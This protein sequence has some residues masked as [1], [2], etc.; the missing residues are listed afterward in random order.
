M[1]EYGEDFAPTPGLI[2]ILRI[3]QSSDRDPKI[4]VRQIE[5]NQ[6]KKKTGCSQPEKTEKRQNVVR[7]TI[8]MSG[9]IH[10]DR[11]GDKIG[12]KDRH[13]RDE[14]GQ[15]KAIA[16]D[17]RNRQI[18]GERVSEIAAQKPPDPVEVL[19]PKGPV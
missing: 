10:P 7:P 16:Y 9:R 6:G 8:L 2:D 15:K 17:L 11:E 13:K 19:F 18:V 12:E 1:G 5:Q 3:H 4:H 14:K